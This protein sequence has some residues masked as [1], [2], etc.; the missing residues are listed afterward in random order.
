MATCTS[1]TGAFQ[2]FRADRQEA[3]DGQGIVWAGCGHHDGVCLVWV[4]V[5]GNYEKNVFL[6]VEPEDFDVV[7][8]LKSFPI[9]AYGPPAG[10]EF[11][12]RFGPCVQVVQ[13]SVDPAQPYREYRQQVW[14]LCGEIIGARPPCSVDVS[15]VRRFGF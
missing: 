7:N 8:G 9:E 13:H 1:L 6:A 4:G 14:Q 12:W 5:R 2:F 11:P 10:D 3:V 15:A